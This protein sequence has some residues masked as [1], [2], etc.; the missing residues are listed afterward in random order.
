MNWLL[1]LVN[2]F[3]GKHDKQVEVLFNTEYWACRRCGADNY[4]DR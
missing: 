2:C 4:R 3:F 1:G